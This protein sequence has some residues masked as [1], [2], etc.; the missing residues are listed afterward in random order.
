MFFFSLFK[1]SI[2]LVSI[3]FTTLDVCI[4]CF[5]KKIVSFFFLSALSEK[6]QWSIFSVISLSVHV[7]VCNLVYLAW[8]S[9]SYLP[10]MYHAITMIWCFV[11]FIVC[12]HQNFEILDW[13]MHI[14]A[15]LLMSASQLNFPLPIFSDEFSVHSFF[16]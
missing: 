9:S 11:N 3:D 6:Q 16:L 13:N 1:A 2:T 8:I 12:T 4:A 14:E 5:S 10:H 7:L 15:G